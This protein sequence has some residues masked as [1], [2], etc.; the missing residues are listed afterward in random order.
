[1]M[2]PCAPAPRPC[3]SFRTASCKKTGFTITTSPIGD[4]RAIE[5]ETDLAT[6][7]AE[8]GP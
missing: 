3:A 6:A 4:Y 1:M 8:L 5:S 2:R 7:A